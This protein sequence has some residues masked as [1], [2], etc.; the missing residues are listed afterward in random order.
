M[1][2]RTASAALAAALAF[3]LPSAAQA[4][5]DDGQVFKYTFLKEGKPQHKQISD[6]AVGKCGQLAAPEG[7]IEEIANESDKVALVFDN[8]TCSGDPVVVAGPGEK[9]GGFSA[10]AVRFEEVNSPVETPADNLVPDAAF[11][12]VG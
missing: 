5:A 4:L 11:S 1:R 8:A 6:L 12:P 9:A 3:V 2:L 7:L 10:V